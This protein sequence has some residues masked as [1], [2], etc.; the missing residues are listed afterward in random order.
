MPIGSP[1]RIVR[2]RLS[3]ALL[4]FIV[5]TCLAAV[6]AAD[7][8]VA[9]STVRGSAIASGETFA[10]P[11]AGLYAEAFSLPA[12]LAAALSTSQP[13]AALRLAAFPIAPDRRAAVDLAAI[14]LYAPGARIVVVEGN[15]E[16]Q[17]PRSARRHFLGTVA[18]DPATRLGVSVD[19]ANGTLRGWVEG[20]GGQF[21]LSPP[22]ATDPTRH[23][24][25]RSEVLDAEALGPHCGTEEIPLPNSL[26]DRLIRVGPTPAKIAGTPTHSAVIGIDTDMELLDEKYNND[27]TAATDD[28]ADLF[29]QMNTAYEGDVSLRL[30]IGDTFLRP[31]SPPYDGDPW[32]VGGS[33]ASGAQL[34]EFGSHWAVNMGSVDRVF[35]ILLS[36]KSSSSN[37]ASGIAWVDGYCEFQS[38]GG[39]YS[40]NQIFTGPFSSATLVA[41]EIGHNAGSP[42]THC[43]SPEVDQCYNAQSGC[44]AGPVSCPGG[45]PGTT[46]S[47]C[48]FGPP[49]GAGCGQNQLTFHPTVVALFDSF[50]ASHS[51]GCVE[52]LQDALIFEDGFESGST[53]AW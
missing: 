15:T 14:D 41:H 31:G 49:S 27:T 43:Y 25:T 34:D 51:P 37:S 52:L 5:L 38:V 2:H 23:R 19:P 40:V 3:I 21:T 32:S 6:A 46:M 36:G 8:P 22:T 16:R 28:I 50:I 33:G 44:Y 11:T 26:V 48:N 13:G 47:Y 18:G 53:S 29:L 17:V 12:D 24:I 1:H 7:E 9:A 35:A 45:S 42:H 30:L 4:G 39:G 10:S 20:P